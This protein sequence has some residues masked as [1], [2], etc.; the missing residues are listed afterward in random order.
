[1]LLSNCY[2]LILQ[3]QFTAMW[4]ASSCLFLSGWYSS[5]CSPCRVLPGNRTVS[6]S[7]GE[8]TK[9][10]SAY[11]QTPSASRYFSRQLRPLRCYPIVGLFHTV[12]AYAAGSRFFFAFWSIELP[13][14]K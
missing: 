1:M 11:A 12:Q 6:R 7:G 14:S 4:W 8:Q 10:V 13:V 2:P 5:S 9:Q 3:L